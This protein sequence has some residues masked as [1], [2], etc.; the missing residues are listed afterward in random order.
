[1]NQLLF[2]GRGN[3]AAKEQAAMRNKLTRQLDAFGA[4]DAVTGV[5]STMESPRTLDSSGAALLADVRALEGCAPTPRANGSVG[6]VLGTART[7]G[8]A[9][10]LGRQSVPT[11]GSGLR[12]GAREGNG[13]I[14]QLL[15]NIEDHIPHS[16]TVAGVS[17][18]GDDADRPSITEQ[19]KPE[20]RT[21]EVPKPPPE[22]AKPAPEVAKPQ[23]EAAKKSEPAEFQ[24]DDDFD[25]FDLEAFAET[26]QLAIAN[27]RK[28]TAAA[29][30]AALT[31]SHE[32]SAK[33]AEKERKAE[34][35]RLARVEA[36]GRALNAWKVESV[37]WSPDHSLEVV[38]KVCK[39][40][41]GEP[42]VRTLRLHD[43]WAES[44]I[45]PG[46]LIRLVAPHARSG[47]PINLGDPGKG[48][49]VSAPIDVTQHSG[50]LLVIH[51]S[52]L[53][54]STAVGGSID[55]LRRTMLQA[56][57]PE[58]GG[59]QHAQ[60]A[61]LGTLAHELSEA[62]LFAA[63]FN[64]GPGAKGFFKHSAELVDASADRLFLS[65][66]TEKEALDRL[67]YVG[68][69]VHKWTRQLVKHPAQPG[70]A[71]PGGGGGSAGPGVE[72]R[73]LA[74]GAHRSDGLVAV[75]KM[76][77]AEE[78]IWAPTLGL[79]GVIDAVAVGKL[80]EVGADGKRM[81]SSGMVPVELKTGYWRE[82]REHGAQLTLYTLM[83]GERY[84]TRVPWG[85]LHYT[86]HPGGGARDKK[87]DETVAIRPGP[88][89]LAYLMHRRNMIAT[90]MRPKGGTEIEE[91]EVTLAGGTLPPIEQC[92]S[93]CERCFVKETCYAVNAALEGGSKKLQNPELVEFSQ[94]LAGHITDAH[95]TELARWLRLIDMESASMSARRATPWMPVEE[96]RKRGGF[97]MD[98]FALRHVPRD[99]GIER[100]QG[101]Q[102]LYALETG[103]VDKCDG[104]SSVDTDGSFAPQHWD[105]ADDSLA[106]ALRPG[107]RLVLSR[108]KG[109]VVV[110]RVILADVK[111]R[112]RGVH[113]EVE[114][115]RPVRT[116]GPGAALPTELW[117][118]D[119]DDGGSTMAGRLRA[120][121]LGVFQSRDPRA[122]TLR[123]RIFDLKPPQFDKAEAAAAMRS[124]SPA[125][126][127][128]VAALNE[129]QRGAVEHILAARDYA[130]VVG[131]PGAGKSATLAATVKALVDMGK[132][133]LITSHTHNAVDNILTR[134]P[135]VG[136]DDFLRVGGED[137]KCAPKVEAYLP[138]GERHRANTS[139]ELGDL[140]NRARV[141]GATCYAAANN[142][143]ITR[144]E[145]KGKGSGADGYF[146]VVL[147]DEAGQMTT[148]A[149][150]APLLLGGV[151]VLV[152]DPH[153]LPPLVQSKEAERLGLGVSLLQRLSEAHGDISV[154][155]LRTQYRM[156]DE[157]AKFSNVLSYSGK[158]R[159]ATAEVANRTL[160][161]P[162]PAPTDFPE[163]LRVATDPMRRVVF[164]DTSSV[165]AAAF[166]REGAKPDN[167]YE[168]GI[169]TRVLRG[170]RARGA[171]PTDCAV[172]SP[173]NAQVDA[174]ARDL[175]SSDDLQEVEALTID[176]AQ[177]RDVECVVISFVRANERRETGGLLSNRR[178]LNV[179]LTRARS[180]L[181]IVG[182]AETLKGSHEMQQVMG[183]CT[184]NAWVTRL[185]GT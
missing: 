111:E 120:A 78:T 34:L 36:E 76:V 51:P 164:L 168:R 7:P 172:L 150:L 65:G 166:E 128:V 178:R 66:T 99:D 102:Y 119:R 183:I 94:E 184:A 123:A 141:V 181:I 133:V 45:R 97:A 105:G 136:V 4:G 167:E 92:R 131:L 171:A 157:L 21:R 173:Y 176:R 154:V 148:P 100:S 54:N 59:A 143:M 98:G 130:L 70:M 88:V 64:T 137:G 144:R 96:V 145:S 110:G 175:A 90:A 104:D 106:A 13:D 28:E 16:E 156:A 18:R 180:K 47:P 1:M 109:A 159:A 139:T 177:G 8:S 53:V 151:F 46:D 80:D 63:A 138:G 6:P 124:L 169:V 75:T 170:L 142:P 10:S 118:I 85:L 126:S 57:V 153:Q 43:M 121:V 32:V 72:C 103:F 117:R 37:G 23:P 79:R 182:N 25:D 58:V 87:D 132:S 20:E 27:K 163:W 44:K 39:T 14:L 52:H 129:E 69:G 149:S 3:A 82:P 9:S 29:A 2:M 155:E 107:D 112:K 12:R 125:A 77:E 108:Q 55:C 17:I 179:A 24:C 84:G 161:A 113:L 158:L 49:D 74:S 48:F 71:N 38:A 147:V 134:L 91:G 56:V 115:E 146:D 83:L 30:A 89:D 60:A 41:E 33:D 174:M 61:M 165:G 73:V 11:P 19:A 185:Q 162:V 67:R 93:T 152:G 114:M 81:V 62:S 31:T 122:D 68:P 86:R 35:E 135:E 40:E 15:G 26:E 140:A 5:E 50:Q 42:D 95:A 160:I 101:R 116:T 22:V 127:T